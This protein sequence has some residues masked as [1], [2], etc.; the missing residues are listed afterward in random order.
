M[1]KYIT[2]GSQHKPSII[3]LQEISQTNCKFL[4]NLIFIIHNS[5]IS[6]LNLMCPFFFFFLIELF[7]FYLNLSLKKKE[8]NPIKENLI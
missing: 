5:D 1:E 3:N 2:Q 6:P 4:G 7:E 8:E